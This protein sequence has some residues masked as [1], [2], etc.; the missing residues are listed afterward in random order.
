MMEG[1]C[2]LARV[3]A[4]RPVSMRNSGGGFGLNFFPFQLALARFAFYQFAKLLSHSACVYVRIYAGAQPLNEKKS[5]RPENPGGPEFCGGEQEDQEDQ[6]DVFGFGR[7]DGM[8][9]GFDSFED[10]ENAIGAEKGGVEE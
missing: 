6:K 7:I 8:R 3:M 1:R 2:G 4:N 5:Y 10:A 9:P